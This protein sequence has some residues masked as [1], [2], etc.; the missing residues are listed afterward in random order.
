MAI[1][2][3]LLKKPIPKADPI[4]VAP[5]ISAVMETI[6]TLRLETVATVANDD[7]KSAAKAAIARG[8]DIAWVG[9]SPQSVAFTPTGFLAMAEMRIMGEGPRRTIVV[10][11]D[12]EGRI[13]SVA[14][15]T[16]D[17]DQ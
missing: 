4:H 3:D 6:R 16:V 9:M 10:S 1:L 5:E 8:H 12:M 11:G 7:L 14:D 2:S 17:V 15:V 13:V